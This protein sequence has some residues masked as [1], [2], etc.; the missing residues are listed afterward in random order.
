MEYLLVLKDELTWDCGNFLKKFS[1][2]TLSEF[3][4]WKLSMFFLIT[5]MLFPF[6]YLFILSIF[7]YKYSF[8][9]LF[10]VL[11]ILILNCFSKYPDITDTYIS[12]H[13][14]CKFMYFDSF[15]LY[16]PLFIKN[17][18]SKFTRRY[19]NKII[20][21]CLVALD[22]FAYN[23]LIYLERKIPSWWYYTKNY[24]YRYRYYYYKYSYF[25]T[26]M[27]GQYIVYKIYKH[28]R[29]V[30][31]CSTFNQFIL[32]IKCLLI[33]IKLLKWNIIYLKSYL[34]KQ[35]IVLP[36]YRIKYYYFYQLIK[37][38]YFILWITLLILFYIVTI[39]F[40]E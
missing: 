20:L 3:M 11:D 36:I 12:F 10:L 9:Y 4:T 22:T 35:T 38:I 2:T 23:W 19:R 16:L 30:Y 28:L 15:F 1:P 21:K 14:Y 25:I 33:Y 26:T 7:I 40:E 37:I 34:K 29:W 6:V 13:E 31:I 32:Y 8:K 18:R 17:L 27:E 5:F 39:F 24:Y